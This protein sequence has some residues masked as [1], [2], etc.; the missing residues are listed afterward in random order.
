MLWQKPSMSPSAGIFRNNSWLNS[1]RRWA[2]QNEEKTCQRSR[3]NMRSGW[4]RN[5]ASISLPPGPS[6]HLRASEV[7]LD[8]STA[9]S[10]LE[11]IPKR[12]CGYWPCQYQP[13]D[14]L[15]AC[16]IVWL[17]IM[18][19][20]EKLLEG[21]W[22]MSKGQRTQSWVDNWSIKKIQMDYNPLNTIECVSILI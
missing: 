22:A 20:F 1:I 12:T 18:P 14:V 21:W 13:L 6:L 9:N 5:V 3:E 16:C 2:S 15:G 7:E 11:C 17:L 8:T 4:A 19:K 10:F